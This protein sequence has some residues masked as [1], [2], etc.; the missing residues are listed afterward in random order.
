[1]AIRIGTISIQ[2]DAETASFTSAMTR[3][4][5][6]SLTSARNVQKSL[7]LIGEAAAAMGTAVAGALGH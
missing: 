7:L 1:M 5:Q 6:V 2:L 3:V 4:E